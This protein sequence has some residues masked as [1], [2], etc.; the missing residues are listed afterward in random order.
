MAVYYTD[1]VDVTVTASDAPSEEQSFSNVLLLAAHNLTTNTIDAVTAL[2]DVVSLGAATNSPLYYMVSGLVSGGNAAPDYTNIARVTPTTF[3]ITVDYI[4]DEGEDLQVYAN[5]GGTESLISYTIESGDTTALAAAGLSA[6]LV[7]KYPSGTTGNPTFTVAS[8][9]VTITPSTFTC[10]FGW[11]SLENKLPHV[12]LGA[13]TSESLSSVAT[14]AYAEDDNVSCLISQWHDS[15]SINALSTWAESNELQYFFS[16][17]DTDVASS[18]VDDDIVSNLG[19]LSL[20]YTA[21]IYSEY[22]EQYFPEAHFLG[23]YAGIAPSELYNPSGWTLKGVPTSS[24][25]TTQRNALSVKNCNFYVSE[26][27]YGTLKDGYAVNGRFVDTVRFCLWSKVT[28][29][30]ALFMLKYRLGQKNKAIPYSD[31]GA[32]MMESTVTSQYVNVGIRSGR[33]AN[34]TTTDNDLGFTIDLRPIV[35]FGTRAQQTDSDI[36]NHIWR[37]GKVEVV[38]YSGINYIKL[39]V[40]VVLNR[41][42]N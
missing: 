5:V 41:E 7:A 14:T 29:A 20:D 37:D 12:K 2:A 24:L 15:T 36:S 34:E 22:A 6:A 33:I 9:V 35:D 27:S 1:T 38:M 17:S 40:Y 10:D 13:T 30:S 23:N 8:N 11:A 21:A 18:S 42:S 32:A 39:N 25:T 28:I 3:T 16:T 19:A 26:H 4:P 31:R